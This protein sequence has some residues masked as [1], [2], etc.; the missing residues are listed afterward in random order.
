MGTC[1]G[2]RGEIIPSLNFFGILSGKAPGLCGFMRLMLK[3]GRKQEQY[4]F[5]NFPEKKFD[6][7]RK[8]HKK[9]QKSSDFCGNCT[10]TGLTTSKSY[11][12]IKSDQEILNK[13]N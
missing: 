5:R 8:L 12:N 7:G 6:K 11:D 10:K 3:G 1:C 2:E 4:L 13:K 9:H